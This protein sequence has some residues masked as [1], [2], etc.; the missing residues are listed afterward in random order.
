M[1]ALCTDIELEEAADSVGT[2]HFNNDVGYADSFI[3][4]YGD[5]IRFIAG[6]ETWL[7]FDKEK[8]WHRDNL[9]LFVSANF[10]DSVEYLS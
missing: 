3:A 1:S 8:G 6:E 7:I 4:K 2:G 10:L 9:T 5:G